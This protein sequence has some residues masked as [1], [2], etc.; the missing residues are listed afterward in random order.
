[1]GPPRDGALGGRTVDMLCG[2]T[3][4]YRGRAVKHR[5]AR[6]RALKRA[7]LRYKRRVP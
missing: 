6:S 1:M 3:R 7:V 4:K 5:M 2:L